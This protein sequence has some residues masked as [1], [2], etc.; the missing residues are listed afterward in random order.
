MYSEFQITDG[1][2]LSLCRGINLSRR[3]VTTSRQTITRS[4]WLK[5]RTLYLHDIVDSV[6]TYNIPNE[7]ISNAD[8]TPSMYVLT[9]NVTMAEK[10]STHVERR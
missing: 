10:K 3:I 4:I 8:Q 7:L 6:V 2:I 1:R 5:V 9:E